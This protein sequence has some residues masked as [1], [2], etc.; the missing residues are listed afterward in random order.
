MKIDPKCDVAGYVSW[1]FQQN[2]FLGS[3]SACDVLS[4]QSK[5][6]KISQCESYSY[7]RAARSNG[8]NGVLY[9][10]IFDSRDLFVISNPSSP[11]RFSDKYPQ[12]G[13]NFCYGNH[14]L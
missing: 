6:M 13:H 8:T 12:D 2:Y 14:S 3:K 11:L 4:F 10:G 1:I 7:Q 9:K 5:C